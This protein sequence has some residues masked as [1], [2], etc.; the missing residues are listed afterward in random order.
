M[1]PLHDPSGDLCRR[2]PL[3]QPLACGVLLALAGFAPADLAARELDGITEDIYPED[4]PEMWEL[5]NGAH[6]NVHNGHTL[7]IT[8]D[9]S[10]VTLFGGTVARTSAFDTVSILLT[11]GS[12]LDAF[13]STIRNG[14]IAVRGSSEVNLV[15]SRI[16]IDETAQGFDGLDTVGIAISMG[17][18][19]VISLI[20]SDI[21]VADNPAKEHFYSGVGIRQQAGKVSVT[22]SSSITAANVGVVL[23]ATK[24]LG[25]PVELQIDGSRVQSGRGPAIEV[26]SGADSNNY[27]IQV[28]NGAILR[29]GD[30]NLLLVSNR[31][32]DTIPAGQSRVNFVVNASDLQGNVTVDDSA[33]AANVH[34]YLENGAHLMGH[35]HQ[36]DYASIDQSTWT[37]SGDSVVRQLTLS[38]NGQVHLG[39]GNTFNTLS[40]DS[41]RSFDGTLVFNVELQGDDSRTDR[42]VIKGDSGGRANVVVTNAGSRGAQTVHGIELISIG[43]DS[44]AEFTLLGRAVGGQ[45]EYFLVKDHN[46][47]WY[48]RS[49]FQEQPE[50]PHECLLE[51]NLPHCEITL[52]VEPIDPENPDTEDPGSENP[53]TEEPPVPQPVLRPETGAY[54]ANQYAMGRLLLH[55]ARERMI[56]AE[57]VEGL[58]S[59]ATTA[60]NE[61]R[62]H[63]PGQQTLR[64]Q[65]QRLQLGADVEAF[66]HGQGRLGAMLTAGRADSTA[67]SRVTGYA[68]QGRVEGGAVGLYAHWARDALYLDASVQH[69][70]FRNRV[71]GEAVALE[72]YDAELW[73][74]ML[75]AGYRFDAGRVG[76]MALQLQPQLQLTHTAR[77]VQAHVEDNG[78]VAKHSDGPGMSTRLGVR[79]QGDLAATY[80]HIKPY[81]EINAHHHGDAD[82][83]RF[84]GEALEAVEP[85]TR[86]TLAVGGQAQFGGGLAAW[87]EVDLGRGGEGYRE[88]GGRVGVSYRW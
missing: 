83:I 59:W 63:A 61:Q 3:L 64:S 26:A 19:A 18:G 73:Q 56:A 10:S 71:Q 66:D 85:R 28:R 54:L 39:D 22:G 31:G 23:Y 84:D 17:E 77:T 67:R 60:H 46:G 35:M 38:E 4:T 9:N 25:T 62:M 68:A 80:A 52:P 27:V 42:L 14:G 45:Y 43:G 13:H 88:L 15:D 53:D 30:G 75:E 79:L 34:V 70:R 41:F 57:A 81:L 87:G 1:T 8:M 24:E 48:L 51:P 49:Q 40:L 58:R 76:S 32:I 12:L 11:G 36:V 44:G 37:L 29:G 78:T 86:T 2:S 5:R 55:R 16:V 74:S 50:T 6:L 69:G 7:G 33:V 21:T 82:G 47:N 65:Q 72:R 20:D